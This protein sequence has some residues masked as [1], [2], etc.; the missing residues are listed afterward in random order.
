MPQPPRR[1]VKQLHHEIEVKVDELDHRITETEQQLL[2]RRL[3]V[4]PFEAPLL[5]VLKPRPKKRAKA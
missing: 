5:P 4:E 1:D 3:A 2:E